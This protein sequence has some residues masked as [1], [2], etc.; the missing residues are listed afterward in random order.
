MQKSAIVKVARRRISA[1]LRRSGSIARVPAVGDAR[2]WSA[3]GSLAALRFSRRAAALFLLVFLVL[4][5]CSPG[6]SSRPK[7]VPSNDPVKNAAAATL[8]AGGAQIS[9]QVSE[10]AG[11]AGP[12]E[13]TW[14]GTLAKGDGQATAKV[15]VNGVAPGDVELRWTGGVAYLSRIPAPHLVRTK[16][17]FFSVLLR[18][19]SDRP[20]V[21]LPMNAGGGVVVLLASAFNPAALLDD[22][23]RTGASSAGTTSIG[24]VS[25]T[26]LRTKQPRPLVGIWQNATVDVFVDAQHR[27]VRVKITSPSGGLSY[28]VTHYGTKVDVAPP[29]KSDIVVG[30][31]APTVE[32][33]GPYTTAASGTTNGIAWKLLRAPAQDGRVCWRWDATP[34]IKQV[35]QDRSDGAHCL[36][37]PAANADPETTVQFVVDANGAGPYDVLGVVLPSG[38][39]ALNLGFAGGTTRAEAV[40]PNGPL[41]V[42]GPTR[43]VPAYLMVTL[44]DGTI[45]DCGA[46]AVGSVADLSDSTLTAGAAAAPWACVSR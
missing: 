21:R 39:K 46:G 40:P 25:V 41:V 29:P 22:M 44:A 7:V 31:T 12:V 13:G 36:A 23:S 24:G 15:S 1:L 42:V 26:D 11:A 20:W 18:D 34:N 4:A 37:P 14:Q 17:G 2:Q 8:A 33:S 19:A 43:P 10:T 5:G 45:L 3:M 38:V 32:L 27:A 6:G 35:L 16:A 28:D 30:G 9:G